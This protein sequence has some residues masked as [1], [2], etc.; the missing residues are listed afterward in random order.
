MKIIFAKEMGFCY[1]V[2]RAVESAIASADT[3]GGAVTLGPIIH[4]PQMVG[5]LKELGVGVVHSLENLDAKKVI[6]RSHG[7]GPRVYQEAEEKGIEILDAT[8]PHVRKVREAVLEFAK[9]NRRIIIIGEADHPEVQGVQEWAGDRSL[10]ISTEEEAQ[11]IPYGDSIGV[12]AQT[13]FQNSIFDELVKIIQSKSEDVA[14]KPTICSAT[15]LR[16]Q[17]VRDLCNEVEL[18]VVVGGKNSGNTKRLAEI[19]KEE[20]KKVILVEIAEE[21]NPEDFTNLESIGITAGASTPDEIIQSVAKRVESFGNGKKEEEIEME[22]KEVLEN[23]ETAVAENAPV[24]ELKEVET[25]AAESAPVVEVKEPV[26]ADMAAHA[27]A[28]VA[29]EKEDTMEALMGDEHMGPSLRVGEKVTGTVNSVTSDGIFLF[30]GG[31]SDGFIPFKELMVP[32]DKSL[33]EAFAVGTEVIAIVLQTQNKEGNPVLS[34]SKIARELVWG[35][36]QEAVEK[37]EALTGKVGEVVKGGLTV[38]VDGIR[39]FV[40]ASQVDIRRVE[41]LGTYV[42]KVLEFIP[43]EMEAAK[44][45]LV[46]SRRALLQKAADIEKQAALAKLELEQVVRGEVKRI[47]AFGAFVDLGGVDGLI[48]LSRLSWGHVRKTSDV[49]KEGDQVEVK[50]VELDK[51]AGKVSLSLKDMAPDPWITTVKSMKVGD[52][53]K[54]TVARKAKFGAFVEVVPGV[55]ALLPLGEISED[56]AEKAL[57]VMEIGQELEVKVSRIDLA[58]KRLTVSLKR[59]HQDQEQAAYQP[60]IAQNEDKLEVSLGDQLADALK[61]VKTEE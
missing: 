37:G 30:I 41:D 38:F 14:I 46:L 40:P 54:V 51:E 50:I 55:D 52:V 39:S 15:E 28:I 24:E 59:F 10:V 58:Q 25:V 34:Q 43:V 56:H 4:N 12:V 8:C 45:R 61:Q 13:T 16:Q 48:H 49:V 6:I 20:G 9:Q 60:F 57:D 2:R 35:K 1:G 3:V 29:A 7:V 31:K 21:L 36:I 11:A 19:A 47:T 22:N 42:G 27:A 33:E 32:E 44:N 26:A 17:A 23:L 5:K 18:V 53:M